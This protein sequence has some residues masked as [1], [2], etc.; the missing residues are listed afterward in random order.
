MSRLMRLSR[1]GTTVLRHR[2]DELIDRSGVADEQ[3]PTP[4]RVLW[5]LSPTRWLPTPADPPARRLRLALE[6]LGPVFIKFGQI[7]STRR[8][9]LAAGLRRGTRQTAG[10][11]AAVPG[12]RSAREDPGESGGT[13]RRRVRFVRRAAARIRLRRPGARRAPAATATTWS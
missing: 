11:R 1:I 4:L 7:L 2:L 9:L 6:A 3:L 10:S 12:S 13:A 8:D 5:R